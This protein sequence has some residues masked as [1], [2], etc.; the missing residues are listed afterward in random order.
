MTP[1]LARFADVIDAAPQELAGIRR[2]V[3]QGQPGAQ[4]AVIL[5]AEDLCA[6]GLA[7]CAARISFFP[8]VLADHIQQVGQAVLIIVAA[9]GRKSAC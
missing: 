6:W 1:A 9:L 7:A 2:V 5:S 3:A 8:I 4:F